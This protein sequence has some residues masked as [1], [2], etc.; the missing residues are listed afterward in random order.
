MAEKLR[1][2]LRSPRLQL[3]PKVFFWSGFL[4]WFYLNQGSFWSW[5]F[6]AAA[7]VYFYSQPLFNSRAQLR[8]F[9]VFMGMAPAVAKA[10]PLALPAL[11]FL[12]YLILG[13]KQ[14]V[15][16]NRE[17]WRQFLNLALFYIIFLVLFSIN[18]LNFRLAAGPAFLAIFL[19]WR[20]FFSTPASLALTLVNLELLWVIGLLP[21]GFLNAANLLW[22][23]TFSLLE[24]VGGRQWNLK[25]GLV[26]AGLA[27]FILLTSRWSL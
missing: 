8:S 26:L 14:L 7:S 13:L 12:F 6:L 3:V 22:L 10:A 9:L 17:L 21:L 24:T 18:P 15:L 23:M 19:L 2:V 25:R 4:G 11:P 20:D 5:F 1:L 16:L 27:F